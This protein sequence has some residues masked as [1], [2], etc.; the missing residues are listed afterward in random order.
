MGVLAGIVCGVIAGSLYNRYKDLKLP[1]YLAFFSGK[2][3]VSIATG[4]TCLGVGT[5][6]GFVWPLARSGIDG[7]GHWLIGSGSI[8]LFLTA[9]SIASSSWRDC[10]T[11]STASCGSSSVITTP[12]ATS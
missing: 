12:E 3:F 8:G 5:V 4:L 11:S 7:L 9:Y 1:A 10:I 2:R 6:L